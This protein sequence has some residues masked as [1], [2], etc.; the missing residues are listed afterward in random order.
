MLAEGE[1]I[2]VLDI[3]AA[4]GDGL[5]YQCLLDSGRAR[6]VGFEPDPVDFGRLAE[7]FGPPHELHNCFLFDG[8]EAILHEAKWSWTSSLLRPNMELAGKFDMLR[9][10]M[11]P[12]GRRTVSTTRLDD[13]PASADADL[14]KIDVQG[15]EVEVL[16]NGVRALS[17]ATAIHIEVSFVELYHGQPMFA[18]VDRFLRA[19]GF[20]FHT[21]TGMISRAFL[22]LANRNNPV[23]A[24]NQHLQADAV[25]VRDWMRF[26]GLPARKLIHLAVI[27]HDVYKSYD[28]A[29]LALREADAQLGTS[30]ASDYLELLVPAV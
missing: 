22:P 14:I 19:A 11:T 2:T 12:A 30:H 1:V 23:R 5:S 29:H 25:Y 17:A 6:L 27:L 15:A 13:I 3:G 9:D 8:R 4:Y 28:L 20:Q 26:H 7:R 10:S 24:F 21:F 18:D 16:K